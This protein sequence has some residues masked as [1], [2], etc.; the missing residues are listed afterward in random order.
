MEGLMS[1]R[2]NLARCLERLVPLGSCVRQKMAM[3]EVADVQADASMRPD[4]L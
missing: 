1:L 3:T 2:A 4:L